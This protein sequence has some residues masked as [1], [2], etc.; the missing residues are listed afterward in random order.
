[1][2]I[3]ALV[4]PGFIAGFQRALQMGHTRVAVAII[5]PK[6]VKFVTN[7]RRAVA[8]LRPMVKQ[9]YSRQN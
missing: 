8:T 6:F 3:A 4:I 5:A 9:L 7:R 1:L 2:L